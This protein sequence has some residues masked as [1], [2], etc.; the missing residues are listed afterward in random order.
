MNTNIAPFSFRSPQVSALDTE[1]APIDVDPDT[2]VRPPFPLFPS[3]Y[4][5][6]LSLFSSPCRKAAPLLIK[7]NTLQEL[8]KSLG[9]SA[10]AVNV[11]APSAAYERP[12][13]PRGPPGSARPRRENNDA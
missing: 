13:G 3:L 10:L 11:V 4:F 2:N 7:K 1:G 9:M 5:P 8:L 12:R 6:S